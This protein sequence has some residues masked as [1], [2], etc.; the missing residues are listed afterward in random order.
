MSRA[1]WDCDF[2]QFSLLQRLWTVP[3]YWFSVSTLCL[4]CGSKQTGPLDTGGRWSSRSGWKRMQCGSCQSH[5]TQKTEEKQVPLQE[6]PGRWLPRDNDQV[7]SAEWTSYQAN[8]LTLTRQ[9]DGEMSHHSPSFF[10][11][12]HLETWER[13]RSYLMEKKRCEKSPE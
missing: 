10:P 12:F 6:Q 5:R 11:G 3:L 8:R 13:K 1:D 2:N 9:R 4:P 7:T